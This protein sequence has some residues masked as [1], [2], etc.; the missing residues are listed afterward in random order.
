MF[1][2]AGRIS[3]AGVHDPLLEKTNVDGVRNVVEASLKAGVKRL[4]HVSSI[5]A[6]STYPNNEVMDETRELAEDER[7]HFPYDRSKVKG[8]KEVLKGIERGLD[9][10]IV[11]PAAVLGPHDYKISE[12]GEV[13]LDIYHGKLPALIDAGYNWVDA[14]MLPMELSGP[15][16]R[17]GRV[18][19]TF[20]RDTGGILP[21]LHR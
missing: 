18:N 19:A 10:V 3:V 1:H 13:F 4:V 9:A 21:N 7:K 5:H 8:Q 11:N 15:T 6:F 17:A 2:L 16:R 20:C 14:G 12:M